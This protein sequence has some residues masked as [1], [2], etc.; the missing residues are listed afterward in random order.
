MVDWTPEQLS[1][2]NSV[3]DGKDGIYVVD[4]AAG[5]GKTT[6]AVEMVKRYVQANPRNKVLMLVRGRDL[7]NKLKKEFEYT[8]NVE[9]AT[10]HSYAYQRITKQ[11]GVKR[12]TVLHDRG[13]FFQTIGTIKKQDE[14]IKYNTEQVEIKEKSIQ[15]LSE[16]VCKLEKSI[17]P[18]I[19]KIR[20]NSA[21]SDPTETFIFLFTFKILPKSKYL[22]QKRIF[23]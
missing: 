8:N 16:Y 15:E 6:T 1:I 14:A 23:Q 18:I 17:E 4:A 7:K 19:I 12:L 20:R 3:T 10:V 11:K 9:C 22:S 21:L 5:S 2:I 13:S